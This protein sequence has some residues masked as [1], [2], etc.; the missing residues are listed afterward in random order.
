MIRLEN[1][2]GSKSRR[3]EQ[4]ARSEAECQRPKALHN[5]RLNIPTVSD[6]GGEGSSPPYFLVR[7][8]DNVNAQLQRARGLI[9]MWDFLVYKGRIGRTHVILNQIDDPSVLKMMPVRVRSRYFDDGR[10]YM[11]RK[12]RRRLGKYEK[13]P[14]LMQTLTYD[15]KKIGKR[16]AWASYGKDTRRF[17]NAV[18]QYRKRRGWRRLHYLWVV[19]VQSGT[20]Y[21]HVHIFFPNLKWI[22]PLSIING[23]WRYGRANIESPK[24]IKVN[25]AAYISKYLRKMQGW[26]DLH[27][28]LLWSGKCRMYSFSRGFSAKIE[29]HESEWLRWHVIETHNLEELEFNL[30]KG[31]YVIDITKF[32]R[33]SPVSLN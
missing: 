31:G 18:N 9:T 30:M 2:V 28:A 6:D 1:G 10:L 25:C 16:E 22:A 14:G 17:I 33:E 29:K 15:P 26:S 32:N 24:K 8:K 3:S 23:N 20:G 21:P 11:S 13:V 7:N 4:V 12:I 5:G 19:E 27:L